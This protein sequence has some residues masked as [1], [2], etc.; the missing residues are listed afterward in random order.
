MSYVYPVKFFAE[1]ERSEFNRGLL[2]YV[3]AL[4]GH[5]PRLQK[6]GLAF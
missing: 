4:Q 6:E 5:S 2:S 1:N 3:L